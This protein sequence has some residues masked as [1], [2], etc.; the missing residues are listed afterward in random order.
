MAVA[1]DLFAE[2]SGDWSSTRD[3]Q[4]VGFGSRDRR[5]RIVRDESPLDYW[6]GE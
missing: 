3:S 6:D 2:E 5:W 1:F 4:K